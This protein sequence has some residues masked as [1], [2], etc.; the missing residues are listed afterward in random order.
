M[1]SGPALTFSSVLLP[2]YPPFLLA[3]CPWFAGLLR[4]VFP[5]GG[6]ANT[7]P[8][9]ERRQIQSPTFWFVRC[10]C[11]GASKFSLLFALQLCVDIS[12][13]TLSVHYF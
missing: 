4:G 13:D 11:L 5:R 12:T 2:R 3:L 8:R 9:Y 7:N 1:T 6:S 10:C